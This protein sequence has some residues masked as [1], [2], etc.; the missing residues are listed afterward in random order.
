MN[1]TEWKV[2]ICKLEGLNTICKILH[3]HRMWLITKLLP[4]MRK[5]HIST[6]ISECFCFWLLAWK[7]YLMHPFLVDVISYF[8]E[9]FGHLIGVHAACTLLIWYF[10]V[11]VS[12]LQWAFMMFAVFDVFA[13]YSSVLH[14]SL[15]RVQ[16]FS[17]MITTYI[18]T[19]L[20][21]NGMT[22]DIFIC[23][24]FFFRSKRFLYLVIRYKK[25]LCLGC[26][27]G[28]GVQRG[29]P[30]LITFITLVLRFIT[31]V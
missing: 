27:D 14:T 29:S 12:G 6:M 30:F 2:F 24:S 25:S 28:H 18:S 4:N 31:K 16:G 5:Q 7:Y 10:W 22:E 1:L 9:S 3:F 19:A 11:I 15:A 21:E 26:G 23:S 8:C 20:K 13:S 17:L